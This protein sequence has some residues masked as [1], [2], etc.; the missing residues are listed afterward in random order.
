MV[1]GRTGHRQHIAFPRQQWL[2]E[3]TS[4]SRIYTYI[5]VI[6]ILYIYI[7][8]LVKYSRI[9]SDTRRTKQKIVQ[10][11]PVYVK[12]LCFRNFRNYQPWSQNVGCW[13]TIPF[14]FLIS[15]GIYLTIVR[16]NAQLYQTMPS[17]FKTACEEW[18]P[19]LLQIN[20]HKLNSLYIL[21][22]C[23]SFFYFLSLT[24]E[25]S[26]VLSQASEK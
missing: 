11:F 24:T 16:E 23:V 10:I 25:S 3:C 4:M 1:Y 8:C 2:G 18:R 9:A 14:T 13:K 22:N 21:R 15:P 19:E 17:Q 20:K 7:A 12:C 6:Y 5:H 26:V